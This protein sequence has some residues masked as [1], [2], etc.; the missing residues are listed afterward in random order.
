MKLQRKE[1]EKMRQPQNQ[2]RQVHSTAI[3]KR[4]QERQTLSVIHG[5]K[6]MKEQSKHGKQIPQNTV[7]T[8]PFRSACSR[9]CH[10][11][12]FLDENWFNFPINSDT[13]W[14]EKR[15]NF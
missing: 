14:V 10:H 3:F 9:I 15:K 6:G 2:M 1:E 7:T 12:L 4:D 13:Q 5:Y 11:G 8:P